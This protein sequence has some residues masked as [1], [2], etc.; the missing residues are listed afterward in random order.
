MRHLVRG[1]RVSPMRGLLANLLHMR[2]ILTIDAE[3]R[4]VPAAKVIGGPERVMAR[5]LRCVERD[6]ASRRDVRILVGHADAP[7]LAARYVERLRERTGVDE[8]PIV[9]VSPALGAHAG[10]GAA[11]IAVS[12]DDDAAGA[13]APGAVGA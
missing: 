4:V 11:G 3:G 9:E 1:G 5:V 8:I 6:V 12:W 2:P 10:P 7:K 13:A